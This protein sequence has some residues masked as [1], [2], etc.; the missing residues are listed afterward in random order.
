[1]SAVLNI[2]HLCCKIYEI[3]IEQIY[4]YWCHCTIKLLCCDILYS[5]FYIKTILMSQNNFSDI[6][7]LHHK[8]LDGD[9]EYCEYA[10]LKFYPG[11]VYLTPDCNNCTCSDYGL[12]C[13]G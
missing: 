13:C 11:S 5:K 6:F 8:N 12:S 3:K 9:E 4:M 1:M 2:K 7:S 10:K